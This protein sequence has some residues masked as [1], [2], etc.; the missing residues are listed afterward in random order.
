M[1]GLTGAD[2]SITW[3]G[4]A[5]ALVEID[6][7]RIMTDPVLRDRIGP[8]NRYGPLIKPEWLESIDAVLVSHAH[9]DHLDPASMRL[10]GEKP[11]YLV[12]EGAGKLATESGAGKVGELAAGDAT[13]LA[14]IEIRAVHAEHGG[15]RLP[16][17]P[18]AQAIGY[19]ISGSRS[20]YFG[21][22]T[23][24]FKGMADLCDDLD[25]A[26]V[27][28]GGWGL[29]RGRRHLNPESAVEA[30][31]LLSPRIAIPI[32]WGTLWPVGM[33]MLRPSLFER[34]GPRFAAIAAEHAPNVKIE[35]LSPGG[36]IAGP[37]R[38]GP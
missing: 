29:T 38:R 17:G 20:V 34:P 23:A 31:K 18:R 3:I 36:Q 10:L 6:G 33:R 24:L 19:I 22:D 1:N 32:H 27:P 37:F 8:L 30:I 26:L 12:P 14:N 13:T 16:F 25:V 11:L 4:H 35:L 28:V 9:R 2:L 21:G 5:T 15:F 7:V